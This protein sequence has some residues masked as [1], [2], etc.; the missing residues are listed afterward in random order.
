MDAGRERRTIDLRRADEDGMVVLKEH[1]IASQAT[2]GRGVFLADEV[3]AHPI[4]DK[5]DDMLGVSG[6]AGERSKKAAQKQAQNQVSSIQ[7]WEV[8][9]HRCGL[10]QRFRGCN[11]QHALLADRLDLSEFNPLFRVR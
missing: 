11:G 10:D 5:H 1:S 3:R 2:E 7:G 9:W 6:G 4:P 8:W